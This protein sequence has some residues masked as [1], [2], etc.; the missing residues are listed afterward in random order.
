[1]Q[2]VVMESHAR[3]GGRARS[4]VLDGS[5]A[6]AGA[7]LFG[8][9]FTT[10]FRLAREAG[11]D[12]LIVRSPGRDAML[13]A[14]RIHPI[15]YGSVSSMITSSALPVRLKLRLGT[16]YVP[17][18]LRHA[19]MLDMADPV[20]AGADFLDNESIASW[21][22]RE[23]GADFVELLAYPLLAA[24]YGGVPEE[25]SAA[26]YH[27]LAWGGLDVSIHAVRGGAG[28][29]LQGIMDAA[30]ARGAR[31]ELDSRVTAIDSAASGVEIVCNGEHRHFD[32]AI[33][34]VPAA[35][36]SQLVS[37]PEQLAEWLSGVRYTSS[38]ALALLLSEAIGV[39]Y[40]GLSLPRAERGSIPLAAICHE[41]NKTDGL[42]MPKKGLLLC[43]SAPEATARMMADPDAA[44]EGM[45]EGVETIYPGTRARIMRA[46]LYRH[47]FGYPLFY[48][49]YLK[50]LRKY[51]AGAVPQN[52]ALAGDYL[53]APSMEGALRSGERAARMLL[54]SGA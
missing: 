5:I 13:R 15:A 12:R 28:A 4:D 48:P 20:G 40:F 45:L 7:Q 52:V 23:V 51:P 26:L 17:Y 32:A 54:E 47:E 44:V 46:K 33:L 49:G 30:V 8:S 50:H 43:L 42:V 25:T 2:P 14:G 37:M 24:Y 6:D 3:L 36:S 18:L 35:V 27:S 9:G 22:A 31:I 29:L 39:D 38:L 53:V 34:A 19:E 16:R 21:G 1:M 10:M 11:V 41:E